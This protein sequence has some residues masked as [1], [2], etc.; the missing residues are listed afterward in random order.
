M[1]Q[2]KIKQ[3]VNKTMYEAKTKR[4]QLKVISHKFHKH[5]IK[6]R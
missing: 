3:Y 6:V 1:T 2:Q 4:E 5:P